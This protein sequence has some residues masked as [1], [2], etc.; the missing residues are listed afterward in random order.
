VGLRIRQAV[1]ALLLDPDDDVLLARFE[2]PTFTVWA[3]PGGGVDEGETPEEGLR[4][5]LH[6]ELGLVG[7][8]LGAHIWNREH[9][10]PMSSGHDGQRDRIHLVRVERFEPVPTI[11]WDRMRAEH[12][13]ELRWWGSRRSTPPRRPVSLRAG[14]GSWRPISSTVARHP[15]RSTR[16]CEIKIVSRDGEHVPMTPS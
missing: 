8:D 7:F 2:F 16:V 15:S 6:E 1:R 4:R 3:L 9:L 5:E 13:Y 11:G 14:S 12:V 10:I